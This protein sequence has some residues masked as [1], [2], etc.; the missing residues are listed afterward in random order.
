[1]KLLTTILLC[2]YCSVCGFCADIKKKA[3]IEETTHGR[4]LTKWAGKDR[5]VDFNDYPELK[6]IRIIGSKAFE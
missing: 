2:L 3:I 6:D 1:M 5:Y 4:K